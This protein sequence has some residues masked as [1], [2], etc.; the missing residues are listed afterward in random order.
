MISG[1]ILSTKMARKV[2]FRPKKI[3]ISCAILTISDRC[4]AGTSIDKSGPKLSEFLQS[5][6]PATF[7]IITTQ[8]I[9]DSIEEIQAFIKY[10]NAQLI[11]TTG[12]TGFGVRDVTPEAVEQL[13]QR[14]AS[15]LTVAMISAS[16]KVSS[17][18]L[19]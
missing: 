12:G 17:R 7:Q 10:S 19:A 14:N 3:M 5:R 11:V 6:S 1:V 13:I 15:G 4:F 2:R 8:T 9:Q 16:L 18:H